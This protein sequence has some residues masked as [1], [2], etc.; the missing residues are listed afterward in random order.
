MISSVL[1]LFDV[2]IFI[3]E[4]YVFDFYNYTSLQCVP[5]H[6][7]MREVGSGSESEE[8]RGHLCR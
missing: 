4:S 3:L 5:F 8:Y 7:E 2:T 6:R 1:E